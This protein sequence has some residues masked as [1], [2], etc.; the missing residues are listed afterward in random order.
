MYLQKSQ[1]ETSSVVWE[2]VGLRIGKKTYKIIKGSNKMDQL[3]KFNIQN[4]SWN[5]NDI[6]QNYRR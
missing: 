3:T 4:N 1:Q 6:S 2:N 5:D